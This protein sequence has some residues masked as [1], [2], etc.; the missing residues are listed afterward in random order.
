MLNIDQCLSEM[1]DKISISPYFD[2]KL[3]V[4][5]DSWINLPESVNSMNEVGKFLAKSQHI[6]LILTMVVYFSIVNLHTQLASSSNRLTRLTRLLYT[7]ILLITNRPQ[8]TS[9]KKIIISLF[10]TCLSLT[11]L[12]VTYR[13]LWF[14]YNSFFYFS[15]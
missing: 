5:K 1:T 10:R 13:S 7:G 3:D 14:K 12:S 8:I 9:T 4:E 6:F 11:M 15:C 2:E